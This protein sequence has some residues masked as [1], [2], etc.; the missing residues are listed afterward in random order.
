MRSCIL[1][2]RHTDRGAPGMCANI[3]SKLPPYLGLHPGSLTPRT[4]TYPGYPAVPASCIFRISK[5]QTLDPS[6]PIRAPAQ[7][8]P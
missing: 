6:R 2:L 5:P 1:H 8:S 3:L 4:R 7:G